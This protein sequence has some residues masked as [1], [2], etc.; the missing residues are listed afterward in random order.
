MSL[1][2]LV[3]LAE[4]STER[5][6]TV[7]PARACPLPRTHLLSDTPGAQTVNEPSWGQPVTTPAWFRRCRKRLFLVRGLMAAI[8]A[9]RAHLALPERAS[10]GLTPAGPPQHEPQASWAMRWQAGRAGRDPDRG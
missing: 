5:P 4:C 9:V 3:P 8:Q 2:R 7:C 10:T 6:A 1:A